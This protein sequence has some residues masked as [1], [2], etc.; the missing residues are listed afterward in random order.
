MPDVQLLEIARIE[1]VYDHAIVALHDVSLKVREREIV[2]LL[3]NNGSRQ[4]HD[5]EGR[6]Q[7][8]FRRNAV[9]SRKAT[10]GLPTST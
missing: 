8:S 6:L 4:D 3:G 7:I 1:A 9:R 2:A 5:A 10:S